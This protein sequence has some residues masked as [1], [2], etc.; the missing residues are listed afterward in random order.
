[1]ITDNVFEEG[2]EDEKRIIVKGMV[3]GII[4]TA[5]KFCIVGIILFAAGRYLGVW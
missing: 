2:E 4:Y 1:M 3:I 5:I